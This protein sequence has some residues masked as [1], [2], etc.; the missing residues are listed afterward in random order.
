M[1]EKFSEEEDNIILDYVG[2]F[3]NDFKKISTLLPH[4]NCLQIKNHFYSCL[5]KR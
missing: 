5:M 1:K 2:K 4:R 3:G